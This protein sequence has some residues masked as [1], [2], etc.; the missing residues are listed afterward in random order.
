[1][2]KPTGS[3]NHSLPEM[4]QM[5]DIVKRILPQGK[6]YWDTVTARYNATKPTGNP[7]IPGHVRLAKDVKKLID[8]AS[9]VFLASDAEDENEV[10]VNDFRVSRGRRSDRGGPSSGESA[11]LYAGGDQ[12][13]ESDAADDDFNQ[14]DS[15]VY[16]YIDSTESGPALTV[17]RED[18]AR[19]GGAAEAKGAAER[20]ARDERRREERREERE[21]AE[22]RR[23]IDREESRAHMREM[24]MMLSA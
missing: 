20:D 22:E 4:Y 2:G 8:D 7:N 17:G 16:T 24:M 3:T 13:D 15:L 23:H 18:R 12:V 1:M 5:L 21:A 19:G 14:L 11:E 9:S 6:D 10:D